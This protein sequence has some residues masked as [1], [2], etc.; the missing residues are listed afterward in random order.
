MFPK[1]SRISAHLKA[2]ILACLMLGLPARAAGSSRVVQESPFSASAI[3]PSSA[4]VDIFPDKDL[5][6]SVPVSIFSHETPASLTALSSDVIKE[7]L[8]VSDLENPDVFLG[9]YTSASL[10]VTAAEIGRVDTWLEDNGL[11]TRVT[12]A[13][14]FMD[15]EFPNP[16]WNIP[17]DL[18]A[19]WNQGAVPFINLAVGTTSLGPRT[20]F[21]VA[22]G[23]LDGAIRTWATN[24]AE[25]TQGGTKHAFIAPLQ[26]MNAGW[27][28]YGLDPENY[29]AAFLHIQELFLEQGVPDDA[30]VWVFAPNGWSLPENKFES[31]YPGDAA[32]DVIGFSAFN[33]GACV[34]AGEG[35]D[36]FEVAIQPYLER[37][38]SMAPEKP[39]FLAQTGSVEQGGDKAA[40][41]TDSF[42]KLSEAPML[43][44][45]LYFNVSK[46]EGAAPSCNP[47]DWRVYKPE[48]DKGE[49]GFIDAIRILEGGSAEGAKF[50]HQVFIPLAWN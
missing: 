41:L 44:G 6:Y 43:R 49:L 22:S 38:N 23:E 34:A 48:I 13:G 39:I 5:S 30:V 40:W 33:F 2:I 18:D 35:W 25:W 15:F 9:L 8:D 47:V 24:F 20:A 29:K 32:V 14:T 16:D 36:P 11:N 46:V 4:P 19:A 12:I 31:Y 7:I 27:V 1:A 42:S 17:H 10:Q 21:Q 26:E 3:G 37:M 50:I 28:T 45:I